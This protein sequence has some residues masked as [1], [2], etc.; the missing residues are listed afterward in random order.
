LEIQPGG[1]KPAGLL[2]TER[3]NNRKY[4]SASRASNAGNGMAAVIATAVW[5]DQPMK[6]TLTISS[7]YSGFG[8]R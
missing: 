5:L 8:V 7:P 6:R 2:E 1:G 3:Q 4:L